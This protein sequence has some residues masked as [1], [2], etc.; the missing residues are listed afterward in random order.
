MAVNKRTFYLRRIFL[1]VFL[2][3]VT[4]SITYGAET[5]SPATFADYGKW[6]TLTRTGGF[7]GLSPDGQWLAYG[8]NRSN[9][10]NE[11]RVIKLDG[12]KTEVVAF[13]SQAVFSSDSL[14]FWGFL[15]GWCFKARCRY[16]RLISS[17]LAPLATPNTS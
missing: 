14:W 17:A 8:I 11:L 7:G 3:C 1:I 4:F 13:G 16:A 5:L 9:G 12:S 6:E 15:S 2:T 10:N